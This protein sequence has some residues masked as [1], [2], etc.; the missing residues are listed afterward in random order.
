MGPALKCVLALIHS[1]GQCIYMDWPLINCMAGCRHQRGL[2]S[3]S[4]SGDGKSSGEAAMDER[5]A[6]EGKTKESYLGPSDPEISCRDDH[7]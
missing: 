4:R 3:V 6:S 1:I 7:Y 5:N 2:V